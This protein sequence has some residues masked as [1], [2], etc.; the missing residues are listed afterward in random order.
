MNKNSGLSRR[1]AQKAVPP[2]LMT[3]QPIYAVKHLILSTKLVSQKWVKRQ[4]K[5]SHEVA[6]AA[7][8][9]GENR[10][11][12]GGEH[13]RNQQQPEQQHSPRVDAAR[14]LCGEMRRCEA[15]GLLLLLLL[16]GLTRQRSR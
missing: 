9:R 11:E 16:R 15:D 7:R 6:A 8:L 13:E 1:R 5:I 2:A 3:F 12:P 10:R 4:K 14:R